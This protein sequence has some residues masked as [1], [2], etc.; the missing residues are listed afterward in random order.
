[1]KT[2]KLTYEEFQNFRDIQIR[3]RWDWPATFSTNGREIWPFVTYGYTDLEDRE[4]VK[5]QI[6]V[7]DE[8]AEECMAIKPLGGRFFIN[9]EGAF[10]KTDDNTLIKFIRFQLIVKD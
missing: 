8:I 5:G 6:P 10:F 2:I 3:L 4:D 1:M 9:D 7:L